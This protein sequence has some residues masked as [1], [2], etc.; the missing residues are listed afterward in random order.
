MFTHNYANDIVS[1]VNQT[2]QTDWVTNGTAKQHVVHYLRKLL[3]VTAN[4]CIF[5]IMRW[6][7][8]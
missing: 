5:A 6:L 3:D 4:N 8:V 7:N 2:S 1:P